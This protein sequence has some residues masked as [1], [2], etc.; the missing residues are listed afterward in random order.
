LIAVETGLRAAVEKVLGVEDL[1]AV[2]NKSAAMKIVFC[3]ISAKWQQ[4]RRRHGRFLQ[5]AHWSQ[6]EI[7]RWRRRAER[8]Q[9][10]LQA[11]HC[12]RFRP[13]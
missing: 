3:L 2:E 1:I 6:R 4:Q 7:R 11:S 9:W 12:Y 10:C 5:E 13:G 8:T